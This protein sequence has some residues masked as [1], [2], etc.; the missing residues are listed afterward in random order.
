MQQRDA[1]ISQCRHYSR[2]TNSG[3]TT[4]DVHAVDV[5]Y[6]AMFPAAVMDA[7]LVHSDL[8]SIEHR[9]L[10]HVVPRVHVTRRPFVVRRQK[11]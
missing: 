3:T 8:R 11:L 7:V 9:R 6:V 10:V 5:V 4:Y 1:A 2:E